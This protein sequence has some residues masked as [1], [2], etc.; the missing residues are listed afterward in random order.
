MLTF[1]TM[2]FQ[3]VQARASVALTSR[4]SDFLESRPELASKPPLVLQHFAAVCVQRAMTDGLQFEQDIA[5]TTYL[6]TL[7]TPSTASE[8]LD[9]CN[10][11]GI[12]HTSASLL[13]V[14]RQLVS[15]LLNN[16]KE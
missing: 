16:L 11:L 8:P 10:T 5:R 9:L 3:K 6:C 15:D 7:F 2:Q 12:E 13:A 1:T 4:I 14:Q